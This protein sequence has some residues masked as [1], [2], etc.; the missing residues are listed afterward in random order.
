MLYR[1]EQE[2]ELRENLAELYRTGREIN[3]WRHDMLG[4][5]EVLYH[6]QK[7]GRYKEVESRMEKL[8]GALKDYPDLPRPTGNDG[9]DAVLIKMIVKCREAN[10]H[11]SYVIL[12]K[13]ER[14]DSIALGKLMNN[15]LLNGLE[16]CLKLSGPRKMELVVHSR[17]GWMEIYLEN[18]IGKSVLADNPR[19]ISRKG[20]R[21]RHGFGRE[22]IFRIIESYKGMYICREEKGEK[23]NRLCQ[24]IYLRYK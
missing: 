1:R 11:F 22:S 15:L 3:R 16:A 6:M 18:S 9:L 24:C 12:G 19:F 17:A 4:E 2:K 23:G 10:I 21:E 7:N 8:C 13:A 5:L 20:D 14:I